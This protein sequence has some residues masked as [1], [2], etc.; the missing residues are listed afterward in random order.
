MFGSKIGIGEI[1]MFGAK[2][3]VRGKKFCLQKKCQ[4]W[5]KNCLVTKC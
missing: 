3:D 1:L 2:I 5:W 4:V